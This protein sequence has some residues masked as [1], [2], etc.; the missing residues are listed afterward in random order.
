[1]QRPPKWPGGSLFALA[2]TLAV[3]SRAH[4]GRQAFLDAHDELAAHLQFVGS[5]TVTAFPAHQTFSLY[6][7]LPTI[8]TTALPTTTNVMQ[9]AAEVQAIQA[10]QANAAMAQQA[11]M[12]QAQAVQAAQA[13]AA[14]AAVIQ[15]QQMAAAATATTA[16]P[17]MPGILG[18]PA[19]AP[20]AALGPA[21]GGTPPPGGGEMATGMELPGVSAA[22]LLPETAATDPEAAERLKRAAEANAKPA[23]P[24]VKVI[25]DWAQKFG[26]YSVDATVNAMRNVVGQIARE[27]A[28]EVIANVFNAKYPNLHVHGVL[29]PAPMSA[30][31]PAPGAALAPGE[32]VV[33]P[34]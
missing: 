16:A 19:A 17:I 6:Q 12:A 8:P 2:F 5:Q 23:G 24:E 18:A 20:G 25:A 29:P 34:R 14:Q 7:Q 26:Q 30:P 32:G 33:G 3:Q 11:A 4:G 9:L 27:K 31:A 21:A 15:Q 1:M 10:A 13:Q 28:E 22:D